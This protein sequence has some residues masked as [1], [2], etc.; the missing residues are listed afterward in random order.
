MLPLCSQTQGGPSHLG[1]GVEHLQAGL[2]LWVL[3]RQGDGRYH[4]RQP[5][6]AR[7]SCL[8]LSPV[9]APQPASLAVYPSLSS[10]RD[11][12][13]SPRPGVPE[14]LEGT[15]SHWLSKETAGQAGQ[16]L[17]HPDLLGSPRW[18]TVTVIQLETAQGCRRGDSGLPRGQNVVVGEVT[19]RGVMVMGEKGSEGWGG[20]G[21]GSFLSLGGFQETLGLG[22]GVG[23][24]RAV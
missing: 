22:L 9:S 3:A 17:S 16:L 24:G 1:P 13:S 10:P 11:E 5:H 14:F 4:R 6:P 18:G 21:C 23:G 7:Q 8:W 12:A 19:T 20:Q 2:S 15:W